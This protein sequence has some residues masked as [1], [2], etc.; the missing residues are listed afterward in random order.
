MATIRITYN[1]GSVGE[2]NGVSDRQTSHI[3]DYLLTGSGPLDYRTISTPR[4]KR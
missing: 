3:D 4:G 2:W 1:D